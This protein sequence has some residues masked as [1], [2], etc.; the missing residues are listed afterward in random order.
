VRVGAPCNVLVLHRDCRIPF[1]TT[2]PD[3]R[4]EI[5]Q[6]VPV[7]DDPCPRRE[8]GYPLLEE[9]QLGEHEAIGALDGRG[10]V[11]VDVLGR[12]RTYVLDD[13]VYGGQVL[14]VLGDDDK[15]P[16]AG[17]GLSGY[18][19]DLASDRLGGVIV[20]ESDDHDEDRL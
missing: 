6:L 8:R 14:V 5:F 18:L 11:E 3:Q 4:L 17:R 9:G 7:A 12:T 16:A 2:F 19:V 20:P 13:E 10:E 1:E 15:G